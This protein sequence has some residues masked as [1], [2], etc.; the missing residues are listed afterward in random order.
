MEEPKPRIT[1]AVIVEH[2]GKVLLG[3]RNKTNCE[4]MWV[5][6][7]G[8]VD[9]GEK[10]KDAAIREIKEET[11]MDVEIVKQLGHQEV[12]NTPGNYHAIVFFHL[13]KSN[14]PTIKAS[15][16]L[17]EAKFF[18]LNEIKELNTVKSVKDALVDAGL[19]K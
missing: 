18:T 7:G 16:D 12:I 4:G 17:S 13:A 8:G 14:D 15:D 1:S 3:R 9:W 19:W 6:P 5:I 2:E 11:G 10:I